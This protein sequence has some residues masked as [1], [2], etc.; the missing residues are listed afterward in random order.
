MLNVEWRG[1]CVAKHLLPGR[2]V[3]VTK[4]CAEQLVGNQ[5]INS[6][7]SFEQFPAA[8]TSVGEQK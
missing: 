8:G 6:L 5:T 7:S 4:R 1:P 2:T 3:H